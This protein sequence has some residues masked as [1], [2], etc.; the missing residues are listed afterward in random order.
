MRDATLALDA[1]RR[2]RGQR[3]V[4]RGVPAPAGAGPDRRPGDAAVLRPAR[5]STTGRALLHRPPARA[6]RRTATRWSSTGGPTSRRAFYR[7]TRD[8]ADGRRRCAAGSASTAARSPPTRTSTCSDRGRGRRGAAA[9]SPARSSGRASARCATSSRPS[10]PSRT[11]SSA[12]T[13]PTTRLR[14]GRARHRQ[15]RGR[16]APR[17][18]PALRLPRP[19]APRPACS[20]SARTAAF[21]AYIGAV[22]PALGEVDVRQTT[23]EELVGQRSGSAAVDRADGRR[24][25]GRRADGR[26][27]APGGVG[28]R[29]VAPTEALVR[30]ARV[31]AVAGARVRGAT[32]SSTSCARRG[33]RY[34]AGRG[35]ARR[36]GWRTHVLL[37]DGARPATRPTTG[38]RTRSPAAAPV[39]G[40][41]DAA[42]AGGRPGRACCSACSSDADGAGRRAP[43]GV[44][45]ADEQA[46]LL[47]PKP[48]RGP[49]SRAAG[50]R[51]TRC[52]VDEAADLLERDAEPRPR[53]A[54]RGAGPVPDA[55]ARGR[56]A[57]L[58]R[59]GDRARRHRPGHHAVG[60]RVVGRRRWRHL[61]KPDA[62][63]EVLDRG[64]RVPAAGDRLRRPAAA[65]HR[66]RARA[67][68][69]RCARTPAA[70]TVRADRRRASR[71]S[72]AAVRRR[73]RRAGLGRRDRRRRRIADVERRSTA[74]RRR[75]R[76]CSA[77]DARRRRATSRSTLVPA[78]LAKGLEFDHVVVVEPAAIV[79]G[80]PTSAPGCA[81]STSCSPA[82]SPG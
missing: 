38:C 26:G 77:R 8:R 23:V 62:H 11:R 41:V 49:R 42:V 51:P 19:A 79:A 30:A 24:P 13:S 6:R 18:V 35:D 4:P 33:V 50:R 69:C 48:A 52:C 29:P 39:R 72:S 46:L 15:D 53:R 7:A 16:P 55:A 70:S 43:T 17:G 82:R 58:D 78:T 27:A 9:S 54:R 67:R 10:S 75:A 60:H 3:G 71:R 22:L 21:L 5:T 68:R 66:A 74:R 1:Q 73:A 65:A 47:W 61:G 2:R 76:P 44:L 20:S 36:S 57:L 56:P 34:G 14:A 32:R 28:A 40:Y 63:V 80:E 81:G 45:D 59:V 12:P 64:F 31:A 37:A 25:Q